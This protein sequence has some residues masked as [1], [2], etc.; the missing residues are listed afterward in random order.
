MLFKRTLAPWDIRRFVTR[1]QLRQ[2][3]AW[4]TQNKQSLHRSYVDVRFIKEHAGEPW[5]QACALAV[6]LAPGLR[7]A[8]VY[9]PVQEMYEL[10]DVPGIDQTYFNELPYPLQLFA[11]QLIIRACRQVDR[12]S[13]GKDRDEARESLINT[14]VSLFCLGRY[15]DE[16]DELWQSFSINDGL[17]GYDME[18][19]SGYNPWD[20]IM[21]D[22]AV[23][24]RFKRDAE[25]QI[26]EVI[27]TEERGQRHP[28]QPHERAIECYAKHLSMIV[29]S[30]G[31]WHPL[32]YSLDLL[33]DQMLFLAEYLPPESSHYF[34]NWQMPALFQVLAEPE[35]SQVLLAMTRMKLKDP[36]FVRDG[37]DPETTEKMRALLQAAGD[38][39]DRFQWL[40]IRNAVS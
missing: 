30:A 29:F 6:R 25:R 14:M 8:Q 11:M 34:S 36:D 40:T 24:P 3:R 4:V 19:S 2:W 38:S 35:Y 7:Y 10:N 16:W 13:N 12:W 39:L 15:G 37:Q 9:W 33:A 21:R 23:L 20:R 22:E 27:V 31:R 1:D 26:R 17:C 28:R 32:P 18:D 5:W